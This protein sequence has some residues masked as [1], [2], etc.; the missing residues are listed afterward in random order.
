MKA[1]GLVLAILAL[2]FEIAFAAK[3]KIIDSITEKSNGDEFGLI[4][5]PGEQIRGDA[6]IP[7]IRKIQDLFPAKSWTAVTDEWFGNVPN[8]FE[9]EGVI[10]DCFQKAQ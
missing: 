10:N 2:T 8:S 3:C 5:I 1:Q 6:Y 9:V 7:L 4:F